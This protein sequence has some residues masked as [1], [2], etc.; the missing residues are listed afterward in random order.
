MSDILN[1]INAYKRGH[2]AA[3]K[4]KRPLSELQAAALTATPPR[5]FIKA[6]KD[7]V[8]SGGYGLIAEIK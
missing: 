6:L 7:K 1:E 5:G 2:I 3:C 8:K 4:A